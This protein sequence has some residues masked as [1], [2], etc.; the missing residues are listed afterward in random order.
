VLVACEALE[1]PYGAF[2]ARRRVRPG[3]AEQLPMREQAQLSWTGSA[4]TG[5]H[6]LQTLAL[7]G[8]TTDY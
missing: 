1:L 7:S 4:L 5:S 8:A 3:E 2:T 6:K